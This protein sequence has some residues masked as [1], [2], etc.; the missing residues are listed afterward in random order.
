MQKIKTKINKASIYQFETF[1]HLNYLNESISSSY[2]DKNQLYLVSKILKDDS[3]KLLDI[4][5]L[6]SPP[7]IIPTKFYDKSIK[8]RY[9]ETNSR[10]SRSLNDDISSDRKITVVYPKNKNLSQ[11]L[12]IDDRE[13]NH[14]NYFT[15]LYNYLI[16]QLNS[17]N[18]FSFFICLSDTSFEIIIFN[19]NEFIFFNSFGINDENEFLYYTF[20]VLKNYQGSVNSDKIIFLGK[21]ERFNK[22]YDLASKYSKIDFID[23]DVNFLV[24]HES[25]SFSIL[26]ENNIRK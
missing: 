15:Q 8:A 12:D 25:K 5:H 24:S 21:H 14:T 18:G 23:D 4:T 7:S 16:G 3:I 9:L 1:F 6:N 20:F 2:S 17:S 13:I 26:N 11:I 10:T 19:K 22:Y